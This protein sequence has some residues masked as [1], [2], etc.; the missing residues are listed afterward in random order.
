MK[1]WKKLAVKSS[2]SIIET[3]K[4]IDNTSSQFAVVVDEYLRLLGTVTDG[5]IRR[6]ILKGVSLEDAIS[7]I[8]NRNPVTIH[9]GVS[10]KTIEELFRKKKLRHLPVIS[11]TGEVVDI[12]L[13]EEYIE[14]LGLDNWVVLMAGGL[15]TRLRPLTEETPKPML[16]VGTK[17]ILQTILESFIDYGFHNFYFSVNYKR[18]SI[19]TYF[20]DGNDWGVSINYLD[21]DQ[22]LGTAGA[23]SLFKNVPTKPI[24][25]MNGDILTKV[26]FKQLL[27]FH[28]ENKSMAT[29]CVREF[30]YQVPYGVVKT[31]GTHLTGIEEKPTESYFVNA[32]IYV[33][34]PK[35]LKMI[36][37]CQYYDMPTLFEKLIND[38]LTTSVFPIREYWLDIGK[39]NDFEKAN[40]EYPG[41]FE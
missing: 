31:N 13:S 14:P 3:M 15:G 20:G 17:P 29:M 32:G 18:E 26:N 23:L 9:K 21:E 2:A 7:K 19:K 10:K 28:E 4:N 38:N 34:N 40:I 22:K 37:N 6:G 8:M 16:K 39:M 12:Y 41:V 33:L 5:D 27:D 24:I 11:N 36:P 30:H 35:V 1:D 25:V